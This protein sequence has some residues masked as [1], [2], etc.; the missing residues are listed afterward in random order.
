MFIAGI[1]VGRRSL[2]GDSAIVQ[3]F[4]LRGIDLFSEEVCAEGWRPP[5]LRRGQ[6]LVSA[7]D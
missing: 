2:A 3:E 7:R 5:R 6:V 4:N 1:D